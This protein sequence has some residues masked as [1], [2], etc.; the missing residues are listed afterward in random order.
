MRSLYRARVIRPGRVSEP[1]SP[2]TPSILS[3]VQRGREPK[4]FLPITSCREPNHGESL[5]TCV[6]TCGA[7]PSFYVEG[8]EV[9]PHLRGGR[10]ENLSEKSPRKK[11]PPVPLT[12]IRISISP[13]SAVELKH[14]KRKVCLLF[15]WRESVY[16]YFGKPPLVHPTEIQTLFDLPAIGGLVYCESSALDREV[17]EAVLADANFPVSSVSRALGARELREDGHSISDLL[18]AILKFFPLDAYVDKPVAVM[19]PTPSDKAKGVKVT[20]WNDYQEIIEKHEAGKGNF[21]V[22][23]RFAFYERAKRAYA[24]VQTG[25]TALYSNIILKKGAFGD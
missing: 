8:E 3:L 22:V 2:R 15:T 19:D 23:E 25:E 24:V 16:N 4:T 6:M 18:E 13:S 7:C 5:S 12:E 14:D 20:I 17:S 1:T 10:V 21:D 9:N 11:P